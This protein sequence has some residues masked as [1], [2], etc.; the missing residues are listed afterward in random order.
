M[1][2]PKN[3]ISVKPLLKYDALFS[4]QQSLM[5]NFLTFQKDLKGLKI[6]WC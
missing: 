1:D 2:K 5:T 3:L 4:L 6:T